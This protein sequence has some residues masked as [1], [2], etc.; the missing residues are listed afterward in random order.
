MVCACVV[1]EWCMR[2]A[3]V[4]R[5]WCMRGVCMRGGGGARLIEHEPSS[6]AA[7]TVRSSAIAWSR[8]LVCRTE[9]LNA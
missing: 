8:N 2:G 7:K 3:C 1:H 9:V 5:A 4:A 6:K